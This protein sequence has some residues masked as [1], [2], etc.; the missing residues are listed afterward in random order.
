MVCLNKNF[1]NLTANVPYEIS[2]E[3]YDWYLINNQYVPKFIVT[4]YQP[5]INEE[6]EY[7]DF[8]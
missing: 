3:G 2:E 4:K 1:G 8:V 7:E 6:A 5:K